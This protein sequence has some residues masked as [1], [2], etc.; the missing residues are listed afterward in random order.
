MPNLTGIVR[1][2]ALFIC[3]STI[4]Q[5]QAQTPSPGG[6]RVPGAHWM[7]YADPQE[8]GF[9]PEEARRARE[10]F[11]AR[12]GSHRGVGAHDGSFH[13]GDID[14]LLG[15]LFGNRPDGAGLRLRG[16]DLEA[17]LSLEFLPIVLERFG[18]EKLRHW[19]H[20]F[21]TPLVIAGVVLSTLHQSS[22]GTMY[23][24][25]P[26]KLH[27]LWYSPSLPFLFYVSAIGAGSRIGGTG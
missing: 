16:Q 5:S 26:S 11:G 19:M 21:N 20:L 27:P 9:D 25:V 14:D 13:F 2:V 8:A 10:A 15:G 1:V 23:V 12:F 4:A 24:I 3:L 22:L 18:F 7:Q 17:R 6:D